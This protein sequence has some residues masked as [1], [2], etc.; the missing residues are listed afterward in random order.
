MATLHII[1]CPSVG[2][3]PG[4]QPTAV[5]EPITAQHVTFT[6]STASA[7]FNAATRIAWLYSTIDCYIAF[8]AAPTATTSTSFLPAATYFP[9]AI[10]AGGKVAAY[11]GTS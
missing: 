11:D 6:T 2:L 3:Q 10:T 5:A 9:F 7:A 4:G 1:E 8:G